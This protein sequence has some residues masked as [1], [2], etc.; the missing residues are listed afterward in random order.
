MPRCD[1]RRRRLVGPEAGRARIGGPGVV[2][3]GLDRVGHAALTRTWPG[4]DNEKTPHFWNS[5]V[6]AA[7]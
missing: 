7:V 3:R 1:R 2:R 4:A 5:S 6:F